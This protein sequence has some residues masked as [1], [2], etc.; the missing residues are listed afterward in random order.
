MDTIE[1]ENVMV[2]CDRRSDI[3][4]N[5]DLFYLQQFRNVVLTQHM[6]FYTDAAVRDMVRC[7]VEGIVRMAAGERYPTELTGGKAL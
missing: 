1:G 3:I 6:A 5:R 2:H 7:G 4:A